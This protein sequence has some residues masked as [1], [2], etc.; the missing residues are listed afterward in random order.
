MG[1][2]RLVCGLTPTKYNWFKGICSG[3]LLL[4]THAH[5]ST[6]TVQRLA[7]YV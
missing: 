7:L 1:W 6:N 5:A 3:A 4:R 2:C